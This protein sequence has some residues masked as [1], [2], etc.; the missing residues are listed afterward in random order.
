MGTESREPEAELLLQ[1]ADAL[2]ALSSYCKH[3]LT[4]VGSEDNEQ[5]KGMV[6]QLA[7]FPDESRNTKPR[8]TK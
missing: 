4:R 7:T 5:E 8:K 2:L 6:Q 3:S 1:Y